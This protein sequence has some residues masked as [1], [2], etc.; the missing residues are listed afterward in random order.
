MTSGSSLPRRCA[1]LLGLVGAA[2]APTDRTPSYVGSAECQSCHETEYEAWQGSHHDLAMDSATAEFVL[3][4]FDD[5]TF[6]YG[7]I[8]S[9]FTTRDGRY[10]VQTDGP[11]G[12]LSEYEI[13][14]TFGFDPLQQ[15]LIPFPDGR[16]QML[17]IAWDARV[18]SEGGQR[19]FHLYPGDTVNAGH[20]LHWTSRDQAW[21]YQC[22]ECHSTDLQKGYDP[23]TDTYET[24]WAEIDV[25]CETCHGPGSG[26]V[27]WA[28]SNEEDDGSLLG[29][30]TRLGR[31]AT[32]RW[33]FASGAT[34]ARPTEPRSNHTQVETCARCHA[35]RGLVS[36]TYEPGGLLL[37]THR[38][39]LLDEGLYDAD[40]QIVEEVYVYGSFLQSKMYKAG[41][42]CSDCHNPHSLYIGADPNAVCMRCHLSTAFDTA[43]HTFHAPADN[44]GCVDCHMA[45][46]PYM[47]VDPRRDHSFRIPRPDLS[48]SIGTTNACT[49][50]H[51]G[52]AGRMDRGG[53]PAVVSAAAHP[54]DRT[55]GP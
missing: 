12:E 8:T 16:Q 44:V 37:E 42:T 22:A 6:T 46:K 17:G 5:A 36:E 49:N 41:V 47:V 15:Y 31:E 45:A 27:G 34:V 30:V 53:G 28:A 7:G 26:H 24:T 21:N 25:S 39:A 40:G 38:P 55:L 23:A 18:A 35:R 52:S 19:W 29:L 2:C 48:A 11:T 9:T 4:D 20:R 54:I 50:C 33:E 51:V 32:T 13:S 10:F 3:G 14:Y 43:A 1:V